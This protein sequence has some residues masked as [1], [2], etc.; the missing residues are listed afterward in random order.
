MH[1]D[2]LL[3]QDACS[4][5]Q[6]PAMPMSSNCGTAKIS[7]DDLSALLFRDTASWY[8]KNDAGSNLD[9]R[10]LTE[11]GLGFLVNE[12]SDIVTSSHLKDLYRRNSRPFSPHKVTE[13]DDEELEDAESLLQMLAD[14]P[15]S[16]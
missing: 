13:S 12:T 3:S 7:N 11:R 16:E 10:G 4:L 9:E 1:V 5:L 8:N 15:T 2:M 14:E 6:E